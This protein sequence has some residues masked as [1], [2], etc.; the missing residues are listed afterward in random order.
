MVPVKCKITGEDV[1]HSDFEVE[2]YNQFGATPPSLSKKERLR[3]LFSFLSG[4]HFFWREVEGTK[5][6]SIYPT[7]APFK[8]IDANRYPPEELSVEWNSREPFLNQ[9][10]TLLKGSP[11]PHYHAHKVSETFGV[12]DVSEIFRSSVVLFSSKSNNCSAS[13]FVKGSTNIGG[14]LLIENSDYC[15]GSFGLKNCTEVV[16]SSNS[17]DCSN[18]YFLSNCK[19]CKNCLFCD[20]LEG[21]EYY[22]NNQSVGAEK[23]TKV[24]QECALH[25]QAGVEL[26]VSNFKKFL[27]Q[28]STEFAKLMDGQKNSSNVFG[29]SSSTNCADSVVYLDGL[30]NSV[31]CIGCGINAERLFNC[32]RCYDNVSDLTYCF[33]CTNSKELIGCV[34]LDNAEYRIL[35]KQYTKSEYLKLKGELIAILRRK[36]NWGNPMGFKFSDFAYNGSLAQHLFPLSRVQVGMFEIGWDEDVE[37]LMVDRLVNNSGLLEQILDTPR[38][39]DEAF[40]NSTGVFVCEL[41]GRLFRYL[42]GELDRYRKL[43]ISPS[44]FGHEEQIRQLWQEVIKV[45]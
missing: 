17:T 19:N 16:F 6:Y 8:V 25:T 9:L 26:A 35:N 11:R 24:L 27:S 30:K 1:V 4:G 40:R 18:S 37:S 41:S 43:G 10:L 2:L 44:P 28:S 36:R 29:T 12:E 13:E 3:L 32:V 20:G 34:G 42:P 14:S 23:F 31:L 22:V 39:L 7:S 33:D 5:V 15:L 45:L 38:D 21:K